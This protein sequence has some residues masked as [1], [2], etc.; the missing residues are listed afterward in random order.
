MGKTV[1]PDL[2]GSSVLAALRSI[3]GQRYSLDRREYAM[4]QSA[5]ALGVTWERIGE[6]LG[7]GS[8]DAARERYADLEKRIGPD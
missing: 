8:A 5:M 4:I 6:A 2:P 1:T 7:L 3:R